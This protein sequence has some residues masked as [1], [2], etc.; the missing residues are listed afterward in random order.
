MVVVQASRLHAAALQ[1]G[2]LLDTLRKSNEFGEQTHMMI[3]CF[4]FIRCH[5]LSNSGEFSL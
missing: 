2:I 3:R 4:L 1:L 5:T